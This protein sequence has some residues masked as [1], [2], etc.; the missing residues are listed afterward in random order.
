M[1]LGKENRYGLNLGFYT[2]LFKLIELNSQITLNY[3]I[4]PNRSSYNGWAYRAE[5]EAVV[6]LPTWHI[7]GSFICILR[8]GN[9][10]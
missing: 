4:F 7:S 10:I 2:Q 1:N 5:I 9:I 6:P 3:H 8:K